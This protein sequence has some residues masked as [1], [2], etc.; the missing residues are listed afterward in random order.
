MIRRPR[1]PS[2][3]RRLR[4]AV[5]LGLVLACA[6][7]CVV[8]PGAPSLLG[9]NPDIPSADDGL[10]PGT[11][12]TLSSGGSPGCTPQAARNECRGSELWQVSNP[13]GCAEVVSLVEVCALGCFTSSLGVASCLVD[14][15]AGIGG[16]GGAGGDTGDGQP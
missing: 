12:G 13:T 10:F 4:N 6:A 16:Q 2:L 8:S 1:R 11:G 3:A 7:S 9:P 15:A 5:A 14:P